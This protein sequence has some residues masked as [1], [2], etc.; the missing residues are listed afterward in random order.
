[1]IHGCEHVF[2]HN[3]L[4]LKEF[5]DA[6]NVGDTVAAPGQR[7]FSALYPSYRSTFADLFGLRL[8]ATGVPVEQIDKSLKPGDLNFITRT[9]DAYVYENPRALPRVML[10][11]DWRVADFAKLIGGR[12]AGRRRSAARPCCW[13][14]R[15]RSRCVM[16]RAPAPRASRAIPIPKS[17]SR[18]MR[19]PAACCCSTT[20]GIR[21][22]ARRSTASRPRSCAPM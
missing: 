17:S 4:R 18:S 3:P 5:Y 12:L 8:I 22:G 1:M 19:R 2:G 15:R 21:G 10:L 6:T 13:R 20:C 9:K 16:S 7:A 11:G 14:T